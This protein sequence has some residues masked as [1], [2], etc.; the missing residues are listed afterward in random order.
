M[1]AAAGPFP[2]PPA[3]GA[4]SKD[5][6]AFVQRFFAASRL[7]FIGSWRRRHAALL[8]G[9]PPAPPLGPPPA[10]SAGCASPCPGHRVILLVDM[11]A[12]F[13]SVAV[14][15]NAKLRGK[16]VAVCWGGGEHAEVSSCSYEARNVGVK[17]GMWLQEARRRC[18]NLVLATY[19]FDA[20]QA[21]GETLFHTLRALSPHTDAVSC[22]EVYVDA[23]HLFPASPPDEQ[24]MASLARRVRNDVAQATGGLPCSVGVGPNRLLA[25]LAATRAKPP[26]DGVHVLLARDAAVALGA[27]VP[28]RELPGVGRQT[29]EA[30]A[31]HFHARTCA[32]VRAVTEARLAARLGPK[33]ARNL[34]LACRGCDPHP[35][36]GGGGEGSAE[37][38]LGKSVGAQASWG[39]RMDTE[40]QVR[41]FI[42][43]LSAEVAGR[44]VLRS[45]A[46]GGGSDGASP[47]VLHRRVA[48]TVSLR[49][50]RAVANAP[51]SLRKGM[52]GHGV[53]DI[54]QRSATTA[55]AMASADAVSVQAKRLWAGMRIPPTEVRGV[56]V[57]LSRLAT[58]DSAQPQAGAHVQRKAR[59]MESILAYASAKATAA[60][61]EEEAPTYASGPEAREAWDAVADRVLVAGVVDFEL[62]KSL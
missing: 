29:A 56:G 27:D 61:T 51:D 13:A 41:E 38:A 26:A 39:V 21:A 47:P 16:P 2:P 58:R 62:V 60:A 44:L 48:H 18:P 1:D 19:A 35:G 49:V 7:H 33:T 46:G 32:D 55:E 43:K 37:A 17:K 22:D 15:D 36:D 20:Y 10:C 24:A 30:L 57:H 14:R 6:P 42:D 11:D 28:A 31:T 3:R 59:R 4:T 45:D 23:T 54:V 52:L 25:K 53:C 12:F 5:D 8:A 34:F 40:D 9:V 50:W